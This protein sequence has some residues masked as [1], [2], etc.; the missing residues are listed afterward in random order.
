MRVVSGLCGRKRV[1]FV[2]FVALRSTLFLGKMLLST[3]PHPLLFY[4]C[5]FVRLILHFSTLIQPK[6]PRLARLR[7]RLRLLPL[8]LLVLVLRFRRSRPRQLVQ[9]RHRLQ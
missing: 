3:L 6:R 4:R 1:F 5:T 8:V 7:L 2:S 9:A